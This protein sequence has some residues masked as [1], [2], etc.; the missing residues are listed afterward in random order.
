MREREIKRDGKTEKQSCL[1]YSRGSMLN[2]FIWEVSHI[3]FLK[4]IHLTL[5]HLDVLIGSSG[6]TCLVAKVLFGIS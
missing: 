5:S 2:S 3:L 4:Q 6:K 1:R